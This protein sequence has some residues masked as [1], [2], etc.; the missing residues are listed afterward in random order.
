LRRPCGGEDVGAV[1][2]WLKRDAARYGGNPDR[3]VLVGSSAG[4]VHIATYL[5]LRPDAREVRG[6]VLLSGLYGF[7]PL[8]SVDRLYFGEGEQ[9]VPKPSL[10]EAVAGS[11]SPLLVACAEFDPPR[12]QREAVALLD[13]VLRARGRLPRTHFASGHNH[14]TLAMHLG[15][16]DTR[17]ADE[18]LD[19]ART[20]CAA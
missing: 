17:L 4:A 2:D 12:F 8:E 13:S 7:T 6:T 10:L 1:V 20:C 15:T 16:A 11:A 3:V 5:Q 19:F 18:I 14:Y 9:A